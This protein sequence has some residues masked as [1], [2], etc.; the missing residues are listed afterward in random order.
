MKKYSILIGIDNYAQFDNNYGCKNDVELYIPILEKQDHEITTLVNE[1]ATKEKIL[2]SL[3]HIIER[4]QINDFINIYFAGSG[5][6]LLNHEEKITEILC[7]YNFDFKQNYISLDRIVNLFDVVHDEIKVQFIFDCAFFSS[8]DYQRQHSTVIVNNRHIPSTFDIENRYVN[9]MEFS[10]DAF[11]TSNGGIHKLKRI[12]EKPQIMHALWKAS[13]NFDKSYEIDINGKIHGIFSYFLSEVA[14]QNNK[15]RDDIFKN[16][17][18]EMTDFENKN[19]I[20]PMQEPELLTTNENMLDA[21]VWNG[22]I[23]P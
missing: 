22:P 5:S 21:S 2:Y 19:N 8:F 16:I 20:F 13:T 12:S 7:P 17:Y 14:S 11:H 1:D 6:S 10:D 15:R 18:K 23:H 9:P 4:L 3:E